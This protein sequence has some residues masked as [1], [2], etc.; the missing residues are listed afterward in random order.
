MVWYGITSGL[1]RFV[2]GEYDFGGRWWK[3]PRGV[4]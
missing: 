3:L 1:L 2:K 4:K